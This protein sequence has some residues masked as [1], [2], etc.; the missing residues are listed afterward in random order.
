MGWNAREC[1]VKSED[2]SKAVTEK[3]E[4]LFLLQHHKLY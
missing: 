3:T 1:E 2:D 4:D